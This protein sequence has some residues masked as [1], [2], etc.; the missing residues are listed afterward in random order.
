[1][2]IISLS[3]NLNK[4]EVATNPKREWTQLW[5]SLGACKYWLI[6]SSIHWLFDS[7]FSL[8]FFLSKSFSFI[9]L[10]FILFP[11]YEIHS[12]SN[13]HLFYFGLLPPFSFSSLYNDSSLICLHRFGIISSSFLGTIRI[14]DFTH[15]C[16]LP[17]F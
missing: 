8:D 9:A 16:C 6:P 2:I 4:N 14:Y 15:I 12:F 3:V 11:T 13:L 17:A 1:M 7:A 10:H 5:A